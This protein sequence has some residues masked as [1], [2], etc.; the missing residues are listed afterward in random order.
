MREFVQEQTK[1]QKKFMFADYI[2]SGGD[3]TMITKKM[4]TITID[5]N[6]YKNFHEKTQKLGAK[7]SSVIER[8][9]ALWLENENILSY[10]GKK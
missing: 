6:V 5:E 2:K 3:K 7:R 8:L 4:L 9:I 10:E 1:T